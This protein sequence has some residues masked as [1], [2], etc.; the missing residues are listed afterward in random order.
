MRLIFATQNRNKVTEVAALLPPNFELLTMGEAGIRVDIPET[1]STIAENSILKA[2]HLQDI[3]GPLIQG[4]VIAED[5]GLEVEALNDAPGV[6]SARYAGE[7][8]NDVANNLKLLQEMA[9]HTNR[10][11]RFVTVLTLILHGKVHTFEGEVRG[12]I[13]YEPRGNAGFGYDPLF[14]PTGYRS[15][16]A[17]LGLEVKNKISHRSKAVNQLVDFFNQALS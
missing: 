3:L 1:G 7:S 16:F 2:R 6:Y 15:T 13:A 8:K 10:K 17:E 11:A 4:S 14:I 5:S 9:I 12:T